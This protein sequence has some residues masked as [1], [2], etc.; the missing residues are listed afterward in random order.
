MCN[1]IHENFFITVL[2]TTV[3]NLGEKCPMKEDNE[4]YYGISKYWNVFI[5]PCSC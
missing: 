3:K 1:D 4:L 2:C 5:M